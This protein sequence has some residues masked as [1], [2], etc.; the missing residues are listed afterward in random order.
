METRQKIKKALKI[1]GIVLLALLLIPLALYVLRQVI[2]LVI[3]LIVIVPSTLFW[4]K[5]YRFRGRRWWR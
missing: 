3:G 4:G 2:A 1:V 5:R